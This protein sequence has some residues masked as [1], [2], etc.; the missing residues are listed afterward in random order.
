MRLTGKERRKRLRERAKDRRATMRGHRGACKL[1]LRG[2][3]VDGTGGQ[4]G[5]AWWDDRPSLGI[6]RPSE[7]VWRACL[8]R[9]A[10]AGCL[11]C[12]SAVP[13]ERHEMPF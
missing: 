5:F 9:P 4:Y 3:L 13:C 8:Y 1:R 6:V 11:Y 2:G 12:A 10:W 7:V